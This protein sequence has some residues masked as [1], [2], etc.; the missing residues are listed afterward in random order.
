MVLAN[1][2]YAESLTYCSAAIMRD[3]DGVVFA[4]HVPQHFFVVAWKIGDP[5]VK[6]RDT[7]TTVRPIRLFVAIIRRTCVRNLYVDVHLLTM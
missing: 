3:F 6:I 2:G 4:T 5:V 7:L 1:R